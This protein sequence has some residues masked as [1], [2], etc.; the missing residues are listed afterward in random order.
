M[1][2]IAISILLVILIGLAIGE[3][4]WVKNV[5]DKMKDETAAVMEIVQATPDTYL[6]ED[7]KFDEYL[8]FR[9][10]DLYNYW[11]KQEKNLCIIIRLVDLSYIS[12]ALI[13]AQ[14]FVHA[15][16][17]EETLAGLRRLEYLLDAYSTIYGFN[18]I[19]IL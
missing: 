4:L 11:R 14:N 5:Y 3:Q 8:R 10:D 16:N 18:G 2:T 13:Y 9:I 15:D 6:K 7:F 12:D 17:K 1:R 19:N